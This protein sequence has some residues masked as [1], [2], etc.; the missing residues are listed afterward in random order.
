MNLFGRLH[1]WQS[2]KF[3]LFRNQFISP[4]GFHPTILFWL[5]NTTRCT[6][7]FHEL[8]HKEI[9]GKLELVTRIAFGKLCIV[10]R[11]KNTREKSS[12]PNRVS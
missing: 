8:G 1:I 6:R 12:K 2:K 4:D 5:L 11:L 10:V 7:I 3:A 9:F